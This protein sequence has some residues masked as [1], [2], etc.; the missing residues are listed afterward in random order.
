MSIK[1]KK[2]TFK[3]IICNPGINKTKKKNFCLKNKNILLTLRN[4]YNYRHPD[5]KIIS[6]NLNIIHNKLKDKLS[7]LCYEERC[8][9]S[10]LMKPKHHKIINKYFAPAFPKEWKKNKNTWLNSL[11]IS[12]V[13]KQYEDTYK[14]FR[15]LGP[16]PIDFNTIKNNICIYPEICNLDLSHMRQRG[17]DKIGIIF[18]TDYH[19]ETG[20]HWIC[21]FINLKKN[22]FFYFD[23]TGDKRQKEIKELFDKLKCGE[24]KLKYKSNENFKHQYKNTE[25]GVYCL[26][27]IINLLT[28]KITI[29]KLKT[30]RISDSEIEKYRDIFFNPPLLNNNSI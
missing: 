22:I 9:I 10:S 23:S 15:F 11:D 14:N 21:V 7:N 3:K 20:S 29:N 17:I 30:K 24:K 2:K 25:C 16:S 1:N 19:Y 8:W 5:S 13:M 4:R 12:R 27:V 26:Y 6:S 28:E 18:N